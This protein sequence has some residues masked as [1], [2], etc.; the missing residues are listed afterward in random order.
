MNE[1]HC[2]YFNDYQVFKT[3]YLINKDKTAFVL[4]PQRVSMFA[5]K[6]NRYDELYYALEKVAK[7]GFYGNHVTSTL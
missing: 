2:D 3:D 1:L 5:I 6:S 7:P 4:G